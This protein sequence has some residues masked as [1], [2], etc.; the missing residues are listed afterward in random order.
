MFT[1]DV[2]M[3]HESNS[4]PT[5]CSRVHVINVSSPQSKCQDRLHDVRVHISI[6]IYIY[7]YIDICMMYIYMYVY[8][9]RSVF[10][11]FKEVP[12][13]IKTNSTAVQ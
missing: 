5:L 6:Y 7:I 2:P 12:K 1:D 4:L 9:Y 10:Q 11:P 13:Q 8:T 3:V